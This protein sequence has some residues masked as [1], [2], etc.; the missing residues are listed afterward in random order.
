MVPEWPDLPEQPDLPDLPGCEVT[1]VS[2]V[3]ER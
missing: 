3:R 2:R 1:A